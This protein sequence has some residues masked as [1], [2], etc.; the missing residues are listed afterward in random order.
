[1]P[2]DDEP[3]FPQSLSEGDGRVRLDWGDRYCGEASLAV[4]PPQR[5]LA[6]IPSWEYL[7]AEHP[8]PGQFRY[9]R[10]AWKQPRGDGVMI[11]LAADGKWPQADE[12]QYHYFSGKNE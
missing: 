12:S 3:E 1:M 9:L 5:F 11:E 6:E 8:E 4:S 7:I 2:F 10:F